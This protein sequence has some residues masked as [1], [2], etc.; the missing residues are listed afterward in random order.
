MANRRYDYSRDMTKDGDT[1]IISKKALA[2][3]LGRSVSTISRMIDDGRL[4]KPMR[5]PSGN[6]GGWFPE[7]I[8]SWQH[9][10]TN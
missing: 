3:K 4:P 7:T 5:T 8:K 10:Q 2:I 9:N 6:V 1:Q